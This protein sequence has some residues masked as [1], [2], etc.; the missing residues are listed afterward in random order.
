ML[1]KNKLD[2]VQ[3]EIEKINSFETELEKIEYS[4]KLK[5]DLINEFKEYLDDI[6]ALI[7]F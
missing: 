3:L 1:S 6:F 5:S 7:K 2:E 4:F